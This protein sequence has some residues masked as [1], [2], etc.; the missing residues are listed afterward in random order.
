MP[1]TARLESERADRA[2][3]RLAG[4]RICGRVDR[5]RGL[6]LQGGAVRAPIFHSEGAR[7]QIRCVC[8]RDQL[9]GVKFRPE[10]GLHIRVRGALGVYE[11]R[12]EYQIYVSHIE[13]MGLGALQLAF[14][15]LKK[16]LQE[17]GLFD[18]ARKKALPVLP[19]CIG[20]VTSPTGRRFATSCGC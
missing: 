3:Q 2:D 10:D 7:A 17:E 14:E 13:P 12:G 6:E 20:I 8:F 11:V 9:R 19:R 16:K 18:E 4:G 1:A 5:G 15:Q